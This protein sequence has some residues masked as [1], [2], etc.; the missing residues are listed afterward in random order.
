MLK[1]TSE[2]TATTMVAASVACGR[3]YSAGV[4]KSEASVMPMAVNT[5]AAGVCAPASKLTTERANPPVTGKPPVKAAPRLLA[6]NATSSWSGSMRWRRLAASVCPTDTDS[7]NPTTLMRSAGTSSDCHSAM[8]N[9]GKVSGGRPCG[10]V[11][12]IF[13]PWLCH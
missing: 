10:T 5:P 2:S 3:K 11:P 8:S 4:R 6:P 7:T 12:T 13:T 1:S 9:S